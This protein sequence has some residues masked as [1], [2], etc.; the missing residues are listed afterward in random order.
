MCYHTSGYSQ[1]T[2]GTSAK[3]TSNGFQLSRTVGVKMAL[4]NKRYRIPSSSKPCNYSVL[5][6][7]WQY[8]GLSPL[9]NCGCLGSPFVACR[10]LR[11]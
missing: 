11:R 9:Q 6:N 8:V 4:A 10:L 5:T 7:T 1:D 3:D 2:I